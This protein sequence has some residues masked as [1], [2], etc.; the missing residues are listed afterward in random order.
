MSALIS[1]ILPTFNGEKYLAESIDS[2]IAQSYQKWELII[3]ND[4]SSDSTMNIANQYSVRDKRITVVKNELNLKLPASLNRGFSLSNGEYLTWTSDDNRYKPTAFERM[5]TI[6]ENNHDIGFVYAD[7][8]VIN[9]D[10]IPSESA[11]QPEPDHMPFSNPVGACFMYK[12]YI[13]ETIGDHDDKLFCAEDYDYWFRIYLKHK[14]VHIHENLYEY[15]VHSNTLTSLMNHLTEKSCFNVIKKYLEITPGIDK[16]IR[17]RVVARKLRIYILRRYWALAIRTAL[18]G[19][20]VGGTTFL[21]SAS[22]IV[23]RIWV[24]IFKKYILANPS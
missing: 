3:V 23:Y 4:C 8:T 18:Y 24:D 14:M 22:L 7:M 11:P 2:I 10:G 19:L 1:V 5:I 17:A 15:R 6:L 12:R 21:A 13:Y 9:P 16:N 20:R